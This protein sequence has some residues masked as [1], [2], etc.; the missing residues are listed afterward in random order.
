MRKKS[1]DVNKIVIQKIV[2]YCN[3][4]EAFIERF[5][6]NFEDYRKDDAFQLSCSACV[7]Q[8]GELTTRLS[9]DFKAQHEEIDWRE[10][11][12]LRNI[13]A[14]EYETVDLKI[15]WEILT[16]NIPELKAQLTEILSQETKTL[17]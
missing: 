3:K 13:H 16:Q 17:S 1:R 9:E 12:G 8:I 11:K 2:D 14:H 6:P 5:G 15:M 7:I 10:I 4:I